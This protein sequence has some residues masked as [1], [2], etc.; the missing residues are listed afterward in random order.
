[1][2]FYVYACIPTHGVVLGPLWE[3]LN[4]RLLVNKTP[5]LYNALISKY[6]VVVVVCK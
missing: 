4:V 5:G 1:M 2:Y 3:A 6:V